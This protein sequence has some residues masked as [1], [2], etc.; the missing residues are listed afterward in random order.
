M[1]V[2]NRQHEGRKDERTKAEE[3]QPRPPTLL[4]TDGGGR[5]GGGGGHGGPGSQGCV[6]PQ[7]RLVEGGGRLKGQDLSPSSSP[8][9]LL[10]LRQGQGPAHH[11]AWRSE[12]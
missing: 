12:L 3:L 5:K 11:H 6:R 9:R 1:C 10:L 8:L 7:E 2:C 4:P